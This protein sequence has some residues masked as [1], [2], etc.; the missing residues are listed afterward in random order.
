M[1]KFEWFKSEFENG[2]SS[3]EQIN[4][5]NRYCDINNLDGQVY[6]MRCID[7]FFEGCTPLDILI[8]AAACDF[9]PNDVYFALTTDGFT[10]FSNVWS[11]ISDYLYDI[12]KCKEAWEKDIDESGYFDEIYEE[13]LDL[14]PKDMD[15]DDYYEIV[16]EAVKE[17]EFESDIEDYIKKYLEQR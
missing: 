17:Y 14:K 4:I 9:D 10:S 1:D 7:E 15:E 11:Y 8:K 3:D 16:N 2:I 5:F 6:P 12:Y 13:Y